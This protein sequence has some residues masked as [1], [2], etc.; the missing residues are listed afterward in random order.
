M[1]ISL[2]KFGSSIYNKLRMRHVLIIR[3][4]WINGRYSIFQWMPLVM[5]ILSTRQAWIFYFRVH[6]VIEETISKDV[7]STCLYS[8]FNDIIFSSNADKTINTGIQLCC[9]LSNPL[10]R[11]QPK[12]MIGSFSSILSISKLAISIYPGGII[13][14]CSSGCQNLDYRS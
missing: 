2:V 4:A 6:P 13:R 5:S 9:H 11:V 12:H 14:Q 1:G 8:Y 7:I 10:Q 3:C